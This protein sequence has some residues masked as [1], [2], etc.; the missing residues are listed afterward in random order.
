MDTVIIKI[1]GPRRFQITDTGKSWFLPEL[2]SRRF[3][4]L[5]ETERKSV[6]P[7]LRR[8]IF[9]PPHRP[10]NLPQIQVFEALSPDKD[11]VRYVLWMQVSLPK[12]LYG[13]S[14]LEVT[15]MDFEKVLFALRKIL[16]DVG[17]TVDSKALAGARVEGAHFC[18]NIL[19]PT[20]MH[21]AEILK[22]LARIDIS[23]AVDVQEKQFKHGGHVLSLY[24][25]TIEHCFYDKVADSL[26]PK[27]KRSD[28]NKINKERDF[29][30]RYGLQDREI[31]RYE[32]RVKKTV[33]AMRIINK[34]LERE[35]KTYLRFSDLFTP[36]LPKKIV[37]SSWRTLVERPENQLALFGQTDR[38]R[39]LSH[40]VTEAGKHGN[41]NS[42][43]N[44]LISYGLASAIQDHGVKEVRRT[45]FDAWSSVHSERLTRKMKVAAELIHGLPFSAHL[46]FVDA[47]IERFEC[48]TKS[49]LNSAV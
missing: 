39:L 16:G 28:K 40:I 13:N 6:R 44:A 41:A 10:S 30:E 11:D 20:D 31:F 19:L 47:A 42:M 14:V 22:E 25:G 48:I 46:A 35:P 8:F 29:I 45:I 32:Y 21:L 9:R 43:N 33:T 38:L 26:R 12:L 27:N 7:Y 3:H 37:L 36:D 49:M 5:S 24:S 4:E 15:E 1:Y 17:I 2:N 34:A 23:K 18:K